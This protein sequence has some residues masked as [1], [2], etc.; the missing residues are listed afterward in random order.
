M[1]RSLCLSLEQF[2]N[3][4]PRSS[5]LSILGLESSIPL[6]VPHI[7]EFAEQLQ[8]I[9][10]YRDWTFGVD[11]APRDPRRLGLIATTWMKTLET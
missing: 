5:I 10:L 11:A 3:V 7:R 4:S 1:E 9:A 8:A 2:V 6:N